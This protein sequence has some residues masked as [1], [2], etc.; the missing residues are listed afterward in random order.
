MGLCEHYQNQRRGLSFEL[1][2]PKTPEAM[3][4]LEATVRRLAKFAPDY[5]TCTYGAGGSSQAATLDVVR[6]LRR[7]AETPVA[8]H[9]TCVGSTVEDLQ[10]YLDRALEAGARYIVA[11]RGDPPKGTDE[12]QQVAGGLRYANELVSLIRASYGNRFGIAVAGYP[13]VHQEATSSEADL[14]NLKRK[15][16]AGGD[17][18][19][20]QLFYDND[21]FYRFRDACEAIGITVPIIP[22]LLPVTNFKQIERIAKLCKASIPSDFAARMNL[23]DASDWQFKV[24]VEHARLQTV[25]LIAH[26]VPGLHY[27]V[28]NQSNAAE[29]LLDGLELEGVTA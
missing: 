15:V 3:S 26:G 8:T 2:P 14:L 4:T 25:D 5:F 20:T 13:E 12:F 21:D 16:D 11:L 10:A 23:S 6:M 18:V 28:L 29:V 24:G 7:V 1:F 9:L 17:V 27:Y 19:I 22:G